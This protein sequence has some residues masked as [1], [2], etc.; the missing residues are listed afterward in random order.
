MTENSH[1][2]NSKEERK[3]SINPYF[4]SKCSTMFCMDIYIVLLYIKCLLDTYTFQSR[5]RLCLGEK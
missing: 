4:R 5:Q 2:N 3:K 1:R